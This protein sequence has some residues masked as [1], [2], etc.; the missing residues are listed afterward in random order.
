MRMKKYV[1]LLAI[2]AVLAAGAWYSEQAFRSLAS[3]DARAPEAAAPYAP[4]SAPLPVNDERREASPREAATA[5]SAPASAAE[6]E[7]AAAPARGAPN[8]TLAAGG[9]EYPLAV[10][11]TENVIDVMRTL[12]STTDFS[13]TGSET[14]SLGFFVESISGRK[15]GEGKY[16][17]LYVN[18]ASSPKGASQT[19]VR[20]GDRI[21]WRYQEAY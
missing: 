14:P 7:Q 1:S 10:S 18:G 19:I 3:T 16:W 21:E 15:S 13:F 17:F 12:A 8:A 20:P 11:G 5:A 2:V 4:E 6:A 9:A